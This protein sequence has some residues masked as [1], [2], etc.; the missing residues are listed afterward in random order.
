[1][2]WKKDFPKEKY[3]ETEKGILYK[4]ETIEIM[5]KF[6]NKIIDT[7]IT[8]PPYGIT[9]CKWDVII[10]FENMWFQLKRIRKDGTPI[11]LFGTEPFAS[12]LRI[13]NLKEYKYDWIWD[14]KIPGAFMVAKYRPLPVY[15]NIIVFGKGKIN[16]YPIMIKGKKRRKMNKTNRKD[17]NISDNFNGLKGNY[18]AGYYDMYY[19][20]NIIKDISNA[21]RKEKKHPTQ[22]P[23]ELMEY[24]IK[25]YS[26][27]NDLILDFTS[28][29]GTTLLACEKLNRRWIGIELDE[30]YCEITKQRITEYLNQNK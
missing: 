19:P 3:F 14:K 4:G 28:G 29:S 12:L 9:S 16:Y 15:E 22:K 25:T 6:P 23:L 8:D 17:G 20:K 1:M 27:E 24:L 26:K 5:S 10:S 11:I 2:N 13:S 18:D 21:N 30:K 7:I